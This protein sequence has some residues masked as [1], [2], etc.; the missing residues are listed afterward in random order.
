MVEQFKIWRNPLPTPVT[1]IGLIQK[2][3]EAMKKQLDYLSNYTER[4]NIHII[5]LPKSVELADLANFICAL[6][7][8]FDLVVFEMPIIIYHDHQT[9]A[10]RPAAGARPRFTSSLDAQL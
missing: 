7:S 8:V 9:A 10:P 2:E 4:E 5:N 3:N 6:C 1:N